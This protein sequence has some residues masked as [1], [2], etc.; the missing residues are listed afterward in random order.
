MEWR[1]FFVATE[2]PV[3]AS[4]PMPQ[5]RRLVSRCIASMRNV[6]DVANYRRPMV[7]LYGTET[8]QQ[9][10]AL[11]DRSERFFG[12]DTLAADMQESE[13][14]QTLL[15]PYDKLFAPAAPL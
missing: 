11:L 12:L 15:A 13:M 5:S 3:Y 7:L 2:G 10:E 9:A 8:A 1:V 14:H 6:D 4:P